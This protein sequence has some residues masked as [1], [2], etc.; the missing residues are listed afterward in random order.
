MLG[1]V[2]CGKN[3]VLWRFNMHVW[4]CIYVAAAV[5]GKWVE[6]V[7]ISFFSRNLKS[8]CMCTLYECVLQGVSYLVVFLNRFESKKGRT[9]LMFFDVEDVEKDWI[10]DFITLI[11]Y[12][13]PKLFLKCPIC[14]QISFFKFQVYLQNT[15][16]SNKQI[17]HFTNCLEIKYDTRV[18]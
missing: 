11:W 8:V 10:F 16:I 3:A 6:K 7:I 15:W 18:I 12:L 2:L 5:E 1:F 13:S 9:F 14:L 4:R 17:G